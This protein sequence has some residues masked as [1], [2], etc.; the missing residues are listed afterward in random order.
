MMPRESKKG[1]MMSC[2]PSAKM[3]RRADWF[4]LSWEKSDLFVGDGAEVDLHK[5]GEARV[6]D[7]GVPGCRFEELDDLDWGC[8]R[9]R[10]IRLRDNKRTVH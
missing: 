4:L 6:E 2:E 10:R 3:M 5:A 7:L 9:A 8:T 1:S